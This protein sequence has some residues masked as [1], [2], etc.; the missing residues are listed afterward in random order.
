ML[1]DSQ[2][3]KD[4][5]GEAMSTHV[6]ICNRCPSSIFPRNITPYEKIF[7]HSPSVIHLQVFRSRCFAKNPDENQSKF[8]DKA[9]ECHL[10]GFEGD[11]IYAVVDSDKKKLWPC[12]IIFMEGKVNRQGANEPNTISFPTPNE[13]QSTSIEEVTELTNKK[14]K[15]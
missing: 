7:G 3:G 11:S 13:P 8:D 6:Y 1:K 12:N 15:K 9:L 14:W 2:P 4:L 10:I 5:W